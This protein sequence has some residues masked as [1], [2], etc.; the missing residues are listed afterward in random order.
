[1]SGAPSQRIGS[2]RGRERLRRGRGIEGIAEGLSRGFAVA[3]D[4]RAERVCGH[5]LVE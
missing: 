3:K 5:R 4:R 2:R 1:M